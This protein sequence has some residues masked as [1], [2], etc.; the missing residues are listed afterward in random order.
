MMA[1]PGEFPTAPACAAFSGIQVADARLDKT[2]GKR[3]V[4][5]NPSISAPISASSDV[6][7][8]VK[9]GAA[10]AA[11]RVG[12]SQKSS[13][14]VLWITVRQIVLSENV[15]RR[16]GYEGRISI[17]AELVR[18]GDGVCWQ[19]RVEG[20]SENYGY[21]GTPENYQETLNHAL[22]RAM[23]RLLGD[24]GFQKNICSCGG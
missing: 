21:S 5:T 15:A 9:A 14:A 20:S 13:G 8:W 4:K 17:T 7:A 18:K 19:D 1:S 3:Y 23:I 16:S 11:Q 6:A 24:P 22:D 10:D 12:I 2:I